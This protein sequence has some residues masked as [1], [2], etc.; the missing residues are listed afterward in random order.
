MDAIMLRD[1][2][3]T[4]CS[5]QFNKKIVY[6]L[7]LSLVHGK[8]TNIKQEPN[9][10][11]IT[12]EVSETLHEN[13]IEYKPLSCKICNSEFAYQDELNAHIASIHVG[14]IPFKCEKNRLNCVKMDQ[15]TILLCSVKI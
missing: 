8:K 5:L 11:E 2:F 15:T 14:N 9:N 10:C 6:D 12:S 3:C 4:D 13:Q 1:M 7:H